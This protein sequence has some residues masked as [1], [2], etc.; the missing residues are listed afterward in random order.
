MR[1]FCCILASWSCALL[2]YS[3][4]LQLP[5]FLF[6]ISSHLSFFLLVCVLIIWGLFNLYLAR[7]CHVNYRSF[8]L[9]SVGLL[10]F[11]FCCQSLQLL[12]AASQLIH[13]WVC[14]LFPFPVLLVY[15]IQQGFAFHLWSLAYLFWHSRWRV[16]HALVALSQFCCHRLALRILE[17]DPELHRILE[18][19]FMRIYDISSGYV[20]EEICCVPVC[21]W[22]SFLFSS[23]GFTLFVGAAV[24]QKIA[25]VKIVCECIPSVVWFCCTMQKLSKHYKY[26]RCGSFLLLPN[27]W[28][29]NEY[30]LNLCVPA[31]SFL[32]SYES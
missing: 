15:G 8:C 21:C 3:R 17:A 29:E 18:E 19:S 24:D 30:S 5:W 31:L 27:Y 32:A 11:R 23:L 9:C 20:I 25:I 2:T 22:L 7:F 13:L 28:P 16:D 1:L 14:S 26:S 4:W 10:I 12:P 6:L